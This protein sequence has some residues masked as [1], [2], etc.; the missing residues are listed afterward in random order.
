MWYYK[1]WFGP[2]L[3]Q[4]GSH[5]LPAFCLFIPMS[6]DEQFLRIVLINR[7]PVSYRRTANAKFPMSR[8]GKS[9]HT[10]SGK[11]FATHS[12]KGCMFQCW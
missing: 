6:I 9:C 1:L 12:G 8:R 4:E 7:S 11:A 10:D 2:G 3:S 5:V